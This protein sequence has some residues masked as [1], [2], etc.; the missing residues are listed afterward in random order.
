MTWADDPQCAESAPVTGPLRHLHVL[1][2]IERRWSSILPNDSCTRLLQ[3]IADV[4]V[5]WD[6]L[7]FTCS[8]K[9]LIS[10]ADASG[11]RRYGGGLKCSLATAERNLAILRERGLVETIRR[12]SGLTFVLNAAF[13][14]QPWETIDLPPVLRTA[15]AKKAS[16]HSEGSVPSH[17]GF[18]PITVR[19]QNP[20]S[21][22]HNRRG[23]REEVNEEMSP[24]S[25][26]AD[27]LDDGW[28]RFAQETPKAA[29]PDKEPAK[30]FDENR[31]DFEKQS[32]RPSL[33]EI[34]AEKAAKLAEHRQAVALARIER[35]R[36]AEPHAR[37]PKGILTGDLRSIWE[38]VYAITFPH[39][40][41]APAWAKADHG[42][43]KQVFDRWSPV[44]GH[45]DE[46]LTWVIENWSDLMRR[47]FGWMGRDG[48][49]GAP[50][51]PHIGFMLSQSAKLEDAWAGRA[52]RAR[53]ADRSL[54]EVEEL[55]AKTGMSEREAIDKI[56]ERKVR[57]RLRDAST[58]RPAAPPVPPRKVQPVA[59][60]EGLP[61]RVQSPKHV[62]PARGRFANSRN[63]ADVEAELFGGPKGA[64]E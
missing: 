57:V 30:G 39:A 20:H 9:S 35:I 49:P 26:G 28:G 36:S 32:A 58:K 25:V 27:A 14:V 60:E 19:D 15:K 54:S 59:T 16:P 12:P 18:S 34:A 44:N 2:A 11:L 52:R 37:A 4:T 48:R 7:E 38:E 10:G 22:G 5:G 21:E 62:A 45:F 53:A 61:A 17:R 6:R 42:K 63:M 33:A 46:Y 55:M 50:E 64:G 13:I 1:R 8:L 40:P 23:I 31:G 41:A 43:A 51:H 24:T 56:V 3:R 47:D 29:R